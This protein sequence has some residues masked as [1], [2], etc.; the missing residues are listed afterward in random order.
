MAMQES[1]AD[2]VLVCY[3]GARVAPPRRWNLRAGPLSVVYEA[4]ELRYVKLG[5]REIIRRWYVAVRD[6]NWGTIAGQ[7]SGEQIQSG[8]SS[9]RLQY[10]ANHRQGDIDFHWTGSIA[11]NESGTLTFEMDGMARTTFLRNRIGFCVLHPIRECAGARCRIETEDG[12]SEDRFPVHIAPANPFRELRALW[13]EV[14]PGVW[15]EIRFSGDLFEMEDQR[16][17]IDASFKTF[18]TPLR[19]PFPVELLA[20]TRVR[21]LVTLSI[22]F[23]DRHLASRH[24]PRRSPDVSGQLPWEACFAP[25]RAA[26]RDC[27]LPAIG[28]SSGSHGRP[29][30]P[31][32]AERLQVL[33]PAHV[34]VELDLAGAD[35]RAQLN[36]VMK[37]AMVLDTSLEAAITVSNDSDRELAG[38][39]ELICQDE[40][41][42]VRPRIGRWLVFH[43]Q[44]WSTSERWIEL[45]RKHLKALDAQIPIYSGTTANFMELNRR[46]PPVH[47]LDGVCYSIHPQEHAFDNS[48]LVETPAAIVD[49]VTTA[50]QFCGDLPLAITPITFRKRVNPYATTPPTPVPIGDLPPRVDPRQM[51]LLGAGWTLASLKY[52]AESG[53]A[54]VTYFE[55]TGFLG[56]METDRGSP[57]PDIFPSR[58]GM[59]FPLYHVLADAAEFA[60]G[61]VVP[62]ESNQ[63]LQFDGLVLSAAGR[64]RIMLANLTDAPNCILLQIPSSSARL[65]VLDES[66]FDQ[67]TLQPE[68]FRAQPGREFTPIDGRW[69]LSLNPFSYARLDLDLVVD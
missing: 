37:E 30:T 15:A 26:H 61:K 19:L 62:F 27:Y 46:R 48:S 13:Q 16:N 32:E 63:P 55:T 38:I 39:C 49:T 11:G 56:V 64:T 50:R 33:R 21:Q 58:P 14:E 28:L 3:Y 60:G 59:V 6:R 20:G 57:L 69:Q 51:S 18:C 67:A 54:S 17:W 52:L 42:E 47:L 34:R 24:E 41:R 36:R 44:E 68:L 4:G 7:L 35:V 25:A 8:E 10:E 53:V 12:T 22:H 29:L 23:E 40:F 2:D 45:A 5:E 31:R 9:F 65:R 43:H 1:I 66:S